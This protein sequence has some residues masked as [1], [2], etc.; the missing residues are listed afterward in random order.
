M[1]VMSSS[2]LGVDVCMRMRSDLFF[3]FFASINDEMFSV[4]FVLF[5]LLLI[6]P[7]REVLLLLTLF[8]LSFQDK[9]VMKR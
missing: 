4:A 5:E 9:F 7:K 6:A 1:T 8:F 2:R 3:Y